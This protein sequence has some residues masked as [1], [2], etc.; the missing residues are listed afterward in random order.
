MPDL[1]QKPSQGIR[2]RLFDGYNSQFYQYC[3]YF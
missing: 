2:F 1:L 3:K